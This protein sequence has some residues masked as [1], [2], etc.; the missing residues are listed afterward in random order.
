M[1]L[2]QPI[3]L[4]NIKH[5]DENPYFNAFRPINSNVNE[6]SNSEAKINL[7]T[8]GETDEHLFNK[9][10]KLLLREHSLDEIIAKSAG[11]QMLTL[12]EPPG[13]A[14]S[15]NYQKQK[16]LKS[17]ELSKR[18][19]VF[20][21]I[22]S[23]FL[24]STTL[25]TPVSLKSPVFMNNMNSD[26]STPMSE[27][28]KFGNNYASN[29]NVFAGEASKVLFVKG[30]EDSRIKVQIIYNLFSNFGNVNKIIFMRNKSGAL[31]E[32]Q[33]VEYATIAKD[34][35]NNLNFFSHYL[36]VINLSYFL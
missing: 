28:N 22:S 6:K 18:S 5:M 15:I 36:R 25:P 17:A 27:S 20:N 14:R 34:F 35:L 7:A 3:S 29:T 32:F 24:D 10:N 21:N 9:N 12:A 2:F 16:V 26:N 19:S 30:L 11:A 8:I 13:L 4:Q 23:P 1:N 31:I 33:S